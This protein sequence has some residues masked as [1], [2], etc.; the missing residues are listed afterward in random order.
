MRSILHHILLGLFTIT[1]N[2]CKKDCT[3]DQLRVELKNGRFDELVQELFEIEDSIYNGQEMN[4]HDLKNIRIIN[5]VNAPSFIIKFY[6]TSD[7]KFLYEDYYNNIFLGELLSDIRPLEI[8]MTPTHIDLIMYNK[9]GY[10]KCYSNNLTIRYF[11]LGQQCE[12]DR[13]ILPNWCV[14]SY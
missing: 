6:T 12:S 5:F 2:G 9:R 8:E 7:T 4:N 11:R 1:T 10:D 13:E 14:H 3:V